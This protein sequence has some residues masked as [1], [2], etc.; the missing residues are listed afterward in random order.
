LLAANTRAIKTI[1]RS[2][3]SIVMMKA[4]RSLTVARARL[5]CAKPLSWP[6]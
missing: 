6:K 3:F 4:K 5:N 2:F 1:G